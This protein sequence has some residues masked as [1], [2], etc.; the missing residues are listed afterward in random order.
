MTG[1]KQSLIRRCL[2]WLILAEQTAAAVILM[3]ILVTMGSQVI[4][5]YVFRAPISWSEELARFG[6]IW[7]TFIASA[8]V[9]AEGRHLAVDMISARLGRLGKLRLEC[10]SNL[11][12]MG[13]CLLLFAGGFRFVWRV[14]PVASPALGISMSWWYGAAL[15]GLGLMLLHSFLNL[16]FAIRTGRPVWE[17]H[18]PG[19]DEIPIQ[20]KGI[21]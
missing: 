10:V 9:M 7:L 12:V 2:R 18:L 4:A 13:T 11:V 8:F 1:G 20:M 21:G 14:Y 5:R 16:I 15:V 6:L 17:E 19:Q 3:V